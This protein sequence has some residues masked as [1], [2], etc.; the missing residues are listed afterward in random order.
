MKLCECGCGLPAPISPTTVSAKGY[1]KGQPR[2]F[3]HNHHKGRLIDGRTPTPEYK[4]YR[5]AKARCNNPNDEW[6]PRYGGR[7]IR[8]LYAD[9]AQF[10]ADVGPRPHPSLTLDRRNNDGNYEP[11]NCR[12]ATRSDQARNR[13]QFTP[14]QHPV[15]KRFVS[16]AETVQDVSAEG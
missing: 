1:I 16:N 9:F 10:L 2:K 3:I 5:G 4:A 8:F 11:G 14:P 7:G 12:W 13:R 6:Y 15:T